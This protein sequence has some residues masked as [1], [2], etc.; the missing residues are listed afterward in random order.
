MRSEFIRGCDAPYDH[1][2]QLPG[3][4]GVAE[5]INGRL[6]AEARGIAVEGAEANCIKVGLHGNRI[7]GIQTKGRETSSFKMKGATIRGAKK[8]EHDAIN[9]I[10]KSK[11]REA[12]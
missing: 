4:K 11:G 9:R 7:Q 3:N 6:W 12:G 2:P 8:V 1:D 10:I 5:A